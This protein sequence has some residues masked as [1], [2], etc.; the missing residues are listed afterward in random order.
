MVLFLFTFK[1]AN[2]FHNL[3]I[4]FPSLLKK[5]DF[6]KFIIKCMMLVSRA[7]DLKNRLFPQTNVID[8]LGDDEDTLAGLTRNL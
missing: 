5:K 4:N 2:Q 1:H 3:K 7:R 6:L 8:E